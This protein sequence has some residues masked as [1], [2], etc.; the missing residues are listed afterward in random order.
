MR[1]SLIFGAA[2]SALVLTA[3]SSDDLVQAP[4]DSNAIGFAVTNGAT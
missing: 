3:C 1:K 4:V 2:A